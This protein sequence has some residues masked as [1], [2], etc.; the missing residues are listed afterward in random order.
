MAI[1][2]YQ[3]S[4]FC[5]RIKF[6][7]DL[8]FSEGTGKCNCT[9]CWKRRM[10]SVR[11]KPENFRSISGADDRGHFGQRGHGGFCKECGVVTYLRVPKAEWNE[12]EYVS[13]AV[14]ALDNLD[15]AELAAAPVRYMDGLHDNWWSEPAEHRH[16]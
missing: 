6:E 1:K 9:S 3:G 11:A 5:K 2:T 4:C 15:P 13:V 14:S 16:L 12:H 10:W 8:D 7:A